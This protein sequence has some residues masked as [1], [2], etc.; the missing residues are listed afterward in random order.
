[1][2]RRR[3]VVARELLAREQPDFF[4]MV[5]MGSDRIHHAFW[6][7]MDEAHRRHEPGHP[8][9]HAIQDYYVQLD[10]EIARLLEGVDLR[11][12]SVLLLSDHGAKRLDGGICVNDWLMRE[13]Y[14][15]LHR[16]PEAGTP[17]AKCDVDWAHTR[18]W[19][20]GG[21]YA[22]IF[23]NVKGRESQGCVEP[24]EYERLRAE[25]G[26]RL[27]LLPDDHGEPLKTFAFKPQQL[28]RA[29]EGIPPDLIVIFGDLNWRALGT[30]GYD[31][32]YRSEN[33]TGPDEANHAQ[34]GF[35]NWIAPTF[36][37][38][39]EAEDLDILDIAPTVLALAGLPVPAAMQGQVQAMAGRAEAYTKSEAS[40]IEKRLEALGY[41]G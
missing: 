38:R 31:S 17:L 18:A 25:L 4:M 8:L 28:Y 34:H 5:E 30:L 29:V 32:L 13:G 37:P 15:K 2:T 22:R 23:L 19:A 16:P 27:A 1:M 40:E 11:E 12:T 24:R 36:V 26:H 21:N 7:Y 41:L 39:A 14:L 35:F 10:G 6:H 33:D 9:A 3:F 20:E